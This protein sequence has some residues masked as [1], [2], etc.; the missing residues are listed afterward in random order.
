MLD[1]DIIPQGDVVVIDVYTSWNVLTLGDI[2]ATVS[3]LT[4]YFQ[5]LGLYNANFGINH[6]DWFTDY[7]EIAGQAS[8]DI[9]V[10]N[11]RGQV[12]QAVA[13]YNQNTWLNQVRSPTV[14]IKDETTNQQSGIDP[15][16]PGIQGIG[17]ALSQ[18][19]DA[20]KSAADS[21]NQT[22]SNLTG[23]GT[24]VVIGAVL[25]FGYRLFKGA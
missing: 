24:V 15:S 6:L 18:V 17:G 7:I 8:Q 4:P 11:L 25:F 13:V 1:T 3:M 2:T 5:G 10:G 21:L 14:V 9:T 12:L 16:S 19:G 23:L 20:A 22:L